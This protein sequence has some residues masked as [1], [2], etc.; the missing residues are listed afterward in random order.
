MVFQNP[1][2]WFD[3]IIFEQL[4]LILNF[5]LNINQAHG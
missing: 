3:K 4:I 5:D 2:A 1:A